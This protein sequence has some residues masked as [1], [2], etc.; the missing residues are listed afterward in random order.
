[1]KARQTPQAGFTL[2]EIMVVVAVIGLLAVMALPAF[3]RSRARSAQNQCISNL[4]LIDGAKAQWAM[5]TFRG[6]GVKPRD[7]DLFGLSLYIRKKPECPAGGHY[8]L[9]KVKDP[10]TCTVTGHT[11]NEF[12]LNE[13]ATLN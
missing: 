12:G 8:D 5:D 6:S 11:L 4:R 9:G 2:T 13:S 1:M 3:A 7:S 10:A